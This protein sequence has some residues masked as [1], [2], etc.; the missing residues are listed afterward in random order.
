KRQK[1]FLILKNIVWLVNWLHIMMMC[2]YFRHINT[3]CF[4]H[5]CFN[6]FGVISTNIRCFRFNMTFNVIFMSKGN[7]CIKNSTNKL[8]S[9]FQE[10][11][12]TS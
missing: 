4:V 8:N 1:P 3:W 5:F 6:F 2:N 10:R 12:Y 11:S 9:N 7:N